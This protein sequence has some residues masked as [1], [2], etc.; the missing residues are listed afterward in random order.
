[1]EI[2]LK[3]IEAINNIFLVIIGASLT[4]LAQYLLFKKQHLKDLKS[5]EEGIILEAVGFINVWDD[6]ILELEFKRN[7]AKLDQILDAGFFSKL[8]LISFQLK[9][10]KNEHIW[11][12]FEN[13]FDSTNTYLDRIK[14]GIIGA[15]E[16]AKIRSERNAIE[17]VF[18]DNCIKYLK[19]NT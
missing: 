10:I 14:T 7:F 13:T 9:R 3:I 5:K 16:Q 6:L 18:F 11:K 2:T 1:M 19:I 12:G 4:Y 15:D 17:K 8:K